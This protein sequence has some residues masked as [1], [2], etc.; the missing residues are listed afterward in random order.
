MEITQPAGHNKSTSAAVE[1]VGRA[2]FSGAPARSLPVAESRIQ[3]IWLKPFSSGTFCRWKSG[4]TT[5]LSP[6]LPLAAVAAAVGCCVAGRAVDASAPA[7]RTVER[8]VSGNC[9]SVS[10]CC[11]ALKLRGRARLR[12]RRWAAR[13]LEH[14]RGAGPAHRVGRRDAIR[15]ASRQTDFTGTSHGSYF[16]IA[17]ILSSSRPPHAAGL[18]NWTPARRRSRRAGVHVHAPSVAS[19]ARERRNLPSQGRQRR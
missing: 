16:E 15:H 4:G 19:G 1:G 5:A 11:P 12:L 2:P 3:S 13:G 6:P 9:V 8:A 14:A 7:S 18:L 10:W 17:W